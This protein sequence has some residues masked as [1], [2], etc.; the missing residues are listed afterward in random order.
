M[1]HDFTRR[2]RIFAIGSRLKSHGTSP[3]MECTIVPA[4]RPTSLRMAAMLDALDTPP[5]APTRTEILGGRTLADAV[6]FLL[7]A[8]NTDR[9]PAG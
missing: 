6:G 8:V 1:A 5:A 9:E 3:V 4:A 2:R 7:S